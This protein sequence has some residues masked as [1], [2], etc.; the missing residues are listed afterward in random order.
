MAGQKG[1]E[2]N[3]W[4]LCAGPHVESTGQINSAAISVDS[5]AGAY[6]RG[7]ETKAQ[8]QRI[9][10]TAWETKDQLKAWKQL[11]IE[12]ARRYDFRYAGCTLRQACSIP[13]PGEHLARLSSVLLRVQRPPKVGCGAQPFQH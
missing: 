4:D 8:L 5:V 10:G 9:Y 1:S 12:A 3:W 2:G 13:Y 11:Q 7:D 6:W